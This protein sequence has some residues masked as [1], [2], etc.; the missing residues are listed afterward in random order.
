MDEQQKKKVKY[1][2]RA[3]YLKDEDYSASDRGENE[4]DP[5]TV[6]LE[7][8]DYGDDVVSWEKE[9]EEMEL[10]HENWHQHSKEYKLY[11]GSGRNTFNFT[12]FMPSFGLDHETKR[13]TSMVFDTGRHGIRSARVRFPRKYSEQE[14]ID[15]MKRFFFQK[16]DPEHFVSEDTFNEERNT[17]ND[18]VTK[19][20]LLGDAM[21]Y[22][23]FITNTN[24][25]DGTC[26]MNVRFGS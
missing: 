9:E 2:G 3:K 11:T 10:T 26:E 12:T 4:Y 21:F 16:V 22:E 14:A 15:A 19:F 6:D 1:T 8:M 17:V 23:G 18:Y 13:F 25:N 20:D 24:K 5:P 7:V